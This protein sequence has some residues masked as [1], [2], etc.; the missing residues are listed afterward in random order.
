MLKFYFT[1]QIKENFP[2]KPTLEQEKSL[3]MLSEY[4]LEAQDKAIL[5]LKGYAGTGKT[6]LMGAFVQ[7]L[8]KMKQKVVLLAPTGRAAKVFATYAG[9]PAYTIHKKIY[10]EQSFTGEGGS[11]VINDNLH[12]HTLFIIDEASMIANDASSGNAFGT[13]YLL[14]DLIS[15]V[16]SGEGCRLI[17]LGDTAQLPPVGEASSPALDADYLKRYGMEVMEM[18]MTEVLRQEQASGILW[19]ATQLRELIMRGQFNVLPKFRF[20][21]FADIR[22]ISG[23]ELIET[24]SD[25]YDHDGIEETIVICRSNKRAN[26]YNNG[27][28]GRILWRE[29]E[30]E[31]GDMLMVT[32]NNYYWTEKE[33]EMDFIAN[34][35]MARVVR[36]RGEREQYGFRF[37]EATLAFPDYNEMEVEVMLLID[38]LQNEAPALSKAESEKLYTKVMEDYAD[39]SLKRERVKKLKSDPY[40]NALQVKYAYAVTCHKAQGGQWKNVFLDQAYVTEEY[41]TPDYFRW[42]YTAVTRA[43]GTLYLVNYPVSQEEN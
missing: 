16:Y 25:C 29:E 33:P 36:V 30:L 26:I 32:K 10:R 6:S 20:K 35:D 37:V 31:S 40:F 38:T 28:R 7:T 42:L 2:Y 43:T 15:Y 4:Y 14:D 34:G 3:N 9:Q 1:E 27:I 21:G 11:F 39:V 19:N 24:I 41:L 12:K 23:D 17:M 5:L 18:E 13:G 22:V 8:H